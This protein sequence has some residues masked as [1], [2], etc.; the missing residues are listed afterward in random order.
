MKKTLIICILQLILVTTAIAQSSN[1]NLDFDIAYKACLKV[2]NALD[3]GFANVEQLLAAAK[4]LEE[5][6]IEQLQLTK[7]TGIKESLKGHFVFTPMFMN[8]CVKNKIVYDI[9]DEYARLSQS[10]GLWPIRMETILV[11]ANSNCIFEIENCSGITN[12]GCVA[13]TS[14]LFSW[15]VKIIENETKKEKTY[16]ETKDFK[17]GRRGRRLIVDCE[18]E[19]KMQIKLIN[20]TSNDRSFCII[21][22]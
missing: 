6:E 3:G 11:P 21:V 18:F 12:I 16:Y 17:K 22:K 13:E 9:A 7:I 15:F 14:G 19:Y 2:N 20:T 10:R 8:E 1:F 5:L 4:T